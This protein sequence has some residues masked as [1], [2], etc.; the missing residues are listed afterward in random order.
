[1]GEKWLETTG[2]MAIGRVVRFDAAGPI[3]TSV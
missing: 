2:E 3:P 1:L